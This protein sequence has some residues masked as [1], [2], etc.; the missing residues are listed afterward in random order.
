LLALVTIPIGA[1]LVR[2]L[3][4][5]QGRGL[6]AVLAGTARLCLWFAVA[7]AAGLVLS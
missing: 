7:F 2:Q 1:M 6:N 5:L 4:T 3:W